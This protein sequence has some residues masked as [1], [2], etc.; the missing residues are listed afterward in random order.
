MAKLSGEMT[1]GRTPET[2]GSGGARR[3]RSRGVR[4]GAARGRDDRLR[5]RERGA[6]VRRGVGA[7]R[8]R[9][10]VAASSRRPTRRRRRRRSS[11]PR[12]PRRW[13]PRPPRRS[14]WT[15]RSEEGDGA[16][17]DVSVGTRIFG[18]IEG[19]HAAAGRGRQD[20]LVAPSRL[21]RACSGTRSSRATTT[22]PPARRS[23]RATAARSSRARRRRGCRRWARAGAEITGVL[24]APTLEEER[25]ALCS[26]AGSSPTRRSA[27]RASSGSSRSRW[28]ARRAASCA[29]GPAYWRKSE[30]QPAKPVRTTIDVGVQEA[31]AT[32]LAG[33]FGGIAALDAKTRRDPRARRHRVLGPAAARVHLQD[34]HDHRGARGEAG[35]AEHR[36]PDPDRGDHR[37]RR[38]GERERGVVRR[39]LR[40]QLRPLV[41]LRLRAARREGRGREARR[42]RRALRLQRRARRSTAPSPS[43][44]PAADEIASPLELGATAIGQGRVLA[45]PLE[46]ATMAQ[47]VASGGIRRTPTVVRDGEPSRRAR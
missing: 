1:R 29:P 4:G 31:V 23:S 27:R 10:D 47:T 21:P 17:V 20:R 11:R 2:A 16:N 41:Q 36:V 7:G 39:Q 5:G 26:R 32:A 18:T 14:T 40:G 6:R 38:A 12:T 45:T 37:R 43:T 42:D 15:T 25:N 34:H 44:L 30:P 22:A 33:R 24:A 46:L 35:Q 28:P 19:T 13:A 8:L 3:P 9:R